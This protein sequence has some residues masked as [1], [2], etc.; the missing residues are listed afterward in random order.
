MIFK[1]FTTEQRKQIH[2]IMNNDNTL[3][4]EDEVIAF[5][6]GVAADMLD[7]ELQDKGVLFYLESGADGKLSLEVEF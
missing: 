6:L 1:T 3:T 5:A 7:P 2:T 4:D